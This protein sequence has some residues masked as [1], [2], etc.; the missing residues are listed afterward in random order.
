MT[1]VHAPELK[2]LKLSLQKQRFLCKL[3][4]GTFPKFTHMQSKS[5]DVK[6]FFTACKIF[7]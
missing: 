5:V 7:H 3:N 4:A 1:I 6:K 2:H